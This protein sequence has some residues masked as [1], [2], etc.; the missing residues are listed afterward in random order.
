MAVLELQLLLLEV[1]LLHISIY[2]VMVFLARVRI[3]L[4][5]ALTCLPVVIQ[6]LLPAAMDVLLLQH[7]LL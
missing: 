7:Q 2:G 3:R 5:L 6:L 4:L 1:E